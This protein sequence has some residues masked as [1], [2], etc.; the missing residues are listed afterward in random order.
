MSKNQI[1]PKNVVKQRTAQV[2]VQIENALLGK[3][4][5]F[6]I[7]L[8]YNRH[9]KD[10]DWNKPRIDQT[11]IEAYNAYCSTYGGKSIKIKEE[12]L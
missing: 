9:T 1:L 3:Y 12:E 7:Y 6:I 5:D 8:L 4:N 2:L 11:L 10:I